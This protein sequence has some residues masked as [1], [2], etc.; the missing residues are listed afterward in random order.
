V[1][2]AREAGADH[3]IDK[4]SEALWPAVE[5]LA[6]GGCDVVLDANGVETLKQSWNHLAPAGRLVAYG[7]STMF[8]RGAGKPSW[9]KLALGWLRT[10]RFNPL[11]MTNLNRSVLAFNLSYLFEKEALLARAMERLAGWAAE[12]RVR[13]PP[14]RVFPLDQ[15]A[16][17][18]RALESGTTTGKLV[19]AVGAGRG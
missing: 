5:R 13:P 15:V 8:A 18:H 1:A 6:P 19:L 10:P 11:D 17:A 16:D 7:F 4:S 9:P 14:V 2:V 12:G 3:V